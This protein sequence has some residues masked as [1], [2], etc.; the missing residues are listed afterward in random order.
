MVILKKA[1]LVLVFTFFCA[2]AWAYPASV[3]LSGLVDLKTRSVDLS[4]LSNSSETFS[5]AKL[6]LQNSVTKQEIVLPVSISIP[7]FQDHK[8]K[9][10][11]PADLK[12]DNL[13]QWRVISPAMQGQHLR[14][15]ADSK[16]TLPSGWKRQSDTLL[17]SPGRYVLTENLIL[18]VPLQITMVGVEFVLGKNASVFLRGQMTAKNVVVRSASAAENWGSFIFAG[19]GGKSTWHNVH[20]DG[21]QDSYAA[22]TFHSCTFCVY[23][24]EHHFDVLRITNALSEDG[25]NAKETKLLL[26]NSH[27]IG[28]MSD[29]L[30]C[31]FCQVEIVGNTFSAI[32]GDAV[33]VSTSTGV[34]KSNTM[35]RI[36]DKAISVG[37]GSQVEV[38]QNRIQ[39]A[40]IGVAVKDKS[41]AL[42]KSNEFQTCE[43]NIA[44]YQK[45]KIWGGAR[46]ELDGN[47]WDTERSKVDAAS[48]LKR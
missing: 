2:T 11:L 19:H 14:L 48:T 5:A 7:P 45:K 38:T 1:R 36:G 4:F 35:T 16:V 6:I 15:K 34:I 32:A 31:D 12:A 46:A 22:G 20:L 13:S 17:I 10:D 43:T 37:E 9:I 41:H 33:D 47:S 25:F 29:A 42:I 3:Y 21:G 26:R 8:L 27:F 24:G 28:T 40:N 39:N 23:G 30:D 44:L 18:D